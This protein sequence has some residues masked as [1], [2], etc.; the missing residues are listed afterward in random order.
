MSELPQKAFTEIVVGKY[1]LVQHGAIKLGEPC[2]IDLFE[3]KKLLGSF[4]DAGRDMHGLLAIDLQHFTPGNGDAVKS[5]VNY[6]RENL[7]QG[8]KMVKAPSEGMISLLLEGKQH[9]GSKLIEIDGKPNDKSVYEFSLGGTGSFGEIVRLP[10]L[11]GIHHA[12]KNCYVITGCMRSIPEGV[13]HPEDV[14][15]PLTKDQAITVGQRGDRMN[16]LD[17]ELGRAIQGAEESI[18]MDDVAREKRAA[19][20][21]ARMQAHAELEKRKGIYAQSAY[22]FDDAMNEKLRMGHNPFGDETLNADG[23]QKFHIDVLNKKGTVKQVPLLV[24][25]FNGAA[26]AF[27]ITGFVNGRNSYSFPE[28]KSVT[29]S[30]AEKYRKIDPND[31]RY[32]MDPHDPRMKKAVDLA[33]ERLDVQGKVR[34]KQCKSGDFTIRYDVPDH[35]TADKLIG[36]AVTLENRGNAEKGENGGGVRAWINDRNELTSVKQRYDDNSWLP[37]NPPLKMPFNEA[38][39][40]QPEK[41]NG[42]VERL[43]KLIK[44]EEDARK[45]T[46]S[47]TPSIGH[48]VISMDHTS[49]VL[50]DSAHDLPAIIAAAEAATRGVKVIFNTLAEVIPQAGTFQYMLT[51]RSVSETLNPQ[52]GVSTTSTGSVSKA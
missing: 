29:V 10:R 4:T 51:G 1:R 9:F 32:N 20:E 19:Q 25:R 23:L 14:Y 48:D 42:L 35:I 11:V 33:F 26:H 12:D 17:P 49:P 5:D 24:G 47:V 37:V 7:V 31:S 50:G 34:E 52:V 2:T 6:L 22:N 30:A 44:M 36:R 41:L 3:G 18:R 16:P 21:A 45:S 40:L 38:G 13:L 46:S 27:V 15:L 28:D 43:R 39:E 8:G